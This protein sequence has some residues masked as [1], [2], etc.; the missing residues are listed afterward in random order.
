[1]LSRR[2]KDLAPSGTVMLSNR[3]AKLKSEGVDVISFTLGEPDFITPKNVI[4]AAKAALDAG[5]THYTPST[6]IKDLREAILSHILKKNRI[7]ARLDNVMVLPAKFALYCAIQSILNDGDEVL[8]PDPGWVSYGPQV[9]MA[10]GKPIPFRMT[11]EDGWHLSPESIERSI[12][13]R[14]KAIIINTPSN[15][16]GSVMSEEELGLVAEIAKKKDLLVIADEVY[17]DLIYEGEHHS[18]GSFEGMADRTITIAGLSK[19]YAMTGWRIG[20]VI[21]NADIIGMINKIQQHSLTCLPG[22]VQRAGL[23]AIIGGRDSVEEM[24]KEFQARR[25]LLIPL[26]N[27]IPGLSC[28]VPKGA[29]Y[30]FFKADLGIDSMKLSEMLL[31]HA[32]VA[33][34]PGS[35]F[36]KEGEGYLRMSYAASRK[37]IE[38][39]M[40]RIAEFVATLG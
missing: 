12:T 28:E 38:E 30:A 1:M 4:R 5:D 37:D 20:W 32:H 15:P 35:A 2:I 36:G 23:E 19:S 22:F 25:D 24:R 34:T 39:G 26:I 33:L 6:G 10:G 3:V 27:S 17:E 21:A 13:S 40:R 8:Y 29:F 31:D 14:T 18:I 9:Q 16:T 11:F 7:Q